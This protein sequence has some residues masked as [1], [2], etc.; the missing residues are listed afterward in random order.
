MKWEKNS[1]ARRTW[2]ILCMVRPLATVSFFT[3]CTILHLARNNTLHNYSVNNVSLPD[4][5]V[6]T[7]LGVLVDNNLRFTKYH[8]SIVNKTNHRSSLIL[9]SFQSR[10]PQLLFR[11][12]T[13]FVRPL[14]DY[15]SPVMSP[16]YKTDINLIESAQRRFT[17][18]LLGLRD[19]SYHDR[20]AILD[21]DD[22]L[23]LP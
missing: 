8:R 14:L 18:R 12:F 13:V 23:R 16:I 7:D 5:S 21:N 11:A 1:I 3:K 22:R 15:C 10:N 6:V 17:K 4:V 20:L 19:I 9:K 2:C